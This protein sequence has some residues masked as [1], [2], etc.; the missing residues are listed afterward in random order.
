VSI[1]VGPEGGFSPGEVEAAAAAGWT[2]A[3]FGFSQLRAETAAA[4]LCGIIVYERGG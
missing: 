3:G 2:V 4:V 1:L